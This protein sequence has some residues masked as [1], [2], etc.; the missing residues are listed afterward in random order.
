MI[1]THI[2]KAVDALGPHPGATWKEDKEW[3][4]KAAIEFKYFRGA[5]RNHTA[6]GRAKFKE[7]EAGQIFQHV[8]N[9][10]VHLSSRLAER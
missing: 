2:E 1:V 9:V 5:W 10:M 4:S 8:K 7:P 6:H 3:Y